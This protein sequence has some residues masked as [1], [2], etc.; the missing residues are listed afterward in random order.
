[1]SQAIASQMIDAALTDIAQGGD[2]ASAGAAAK[3]QALM[4]QPHLVPPGT[5]HDGADGGSVIAQMLTTHD[6]AAQHAMDRVS[7][8]SEQSAHMDVKQVLAESA[9]AAMEMYRVQF[10]FQAK[11][12]VVSSSRSSAETLMKNQ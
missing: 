10:D 12:S 7:Q 1:M 2:A 3:F 8:F 4:N 6:A 9:D 11:M 5:H